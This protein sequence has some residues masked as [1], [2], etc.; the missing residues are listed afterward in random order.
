MYRSLDSEKI[1]GTIGRL[2]TRID[3]RFPS[4]GLGRVCKELLT[5]A[6]ES[7]Q[8]S[9]WIAKPQKSLRVIVGVLIALIVIVLVLVLA[10]STVPLNRFDFVVLLQ[11]SEAG[12]NVFIL[13]G[14][15][16]LFLIT[17]EVR[18]KRSRALKAIHELRALA[19]V[20]DMHQ[21][22]KESFLIREAE[23]TSSPTQNL[24][25]TQIVRYLDYCSEMLSL[26][27]KLAALYVQKFDDP[28][29][30]AAVNEVEDLDYGTLAQDLAEDHG[31]SFRSCYR[32]LTIRTIIL[33]SI[34]LVLSSAGVSVAQVDDAERRAW[35]RPVKPFRVVENIYYVGAE[36]VAS[37]LITTRQGHILMD[38]GFAETVP[39]IQD[40]LNQL[41]FKLKDVK[42][43]I[44]SHAHFD[45]AG[46]L[47]QLKK[48]TGARLMISEAD[49]E[50]I[51]DGGRS[52]FQWRDKASFH[53]E[54]AVID[55]LLRDQDKVELGGVTMIARITP[56]HTKGC[57]TW[58]M[59]VREAGQDLD[60][61]F[62][63]STT[64][65]GY[66]LL[67]NSAYPKIVED[68][69]YTFA[70][71]KTLRCDVFLAPH[72]SFFALD[73]KRQMLEKGTKTNPFIDPQSYR[74]FIN[75]TERAYQKQLEEER[76]KGK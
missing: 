11:V 5:I 52:D 8:R 10:N 25:A 39:R 24:T 33:F 63:G 69:A 16:I 50:L 31:L 23:T 53:F 75:A 3:E 61:V 20:I 13:L 6:G 76:E 2:C 41:G 71:L 56:G 7:Q 70:L 44:N 19:H 62:V 65:P 45:H 46:G 51:G 59:K 74:R 29:A 27:G 68:Y 14:A 17:S 42:V 49:A 54:P 73:E 48:L 38:S 40:S 36:N 47:A 4:S 55:R 72:G 58:T 60:V 15:A 12:I 43:L 30:L 66:K 57:T 64:I 35:N 26:I 18:M 1:I 37:Y 9:A 28:V 21:L 32:R 67:K 34:A 22:T